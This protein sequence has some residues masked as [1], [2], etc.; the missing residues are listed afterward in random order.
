[1]KPIALITGITGQDGAYLAKSL[2]NN[3]YKVI[4]GSPRRA[5]QNYGNL[6]DLGLIG[7]K[8]LELIS[9]DITCSVSVDRV[10]ERYKPARVFN[11]AAQSFV[12][13]SFLS[14]LATANINYIGVVNM[15]EA[16]RR[17]VPGCRFYQASTS[18]MFG[19]VNV[20]AQNEKTP[21]HPRSPYGVAKVAAHWATINYRE[22]YGL[23]A[24]C[25]ILFNHESPLRGKEFVTRKVTDA[26]AR[27]VTGR[28]KKLHL[29]NITAKRD[30]GH[31]AEYVEAM[32]L[33]LDQ[34]VPDDY[35]I[36]TGKTYT[37][38]DMVE[39]AFEHAGLDI[40]EHLVIDKDLYRPSDVPLLRGDA[41][42]AN[43]VLGWKPKISFRRMIKEMVDADLQRYS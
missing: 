38:R 20:E 23:H 28:Q 17:L 4:G 33:M 1:M 40:D 8:D 25:G 3:G 43:K 29:G 30:W 7:A 34:A 22:A 5:N 32:R 11:L 26:C 12:A 6:A 14:P 10:I 9:L 42:K 31:A 24:S 41:S 2:L 36:A 18:E 37:V 35:V 39:I 16:I 27:I 19:L 15:L 21:F 13:E